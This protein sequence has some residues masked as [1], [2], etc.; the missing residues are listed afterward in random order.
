MAHDSCYALFRP[1]T[2]AN[3]IIQFHLSTN[4]VLSITEIVLK[5]IGFTTK[6][7]KQTTFSLFRE[8]ASC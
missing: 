6:I 5:E 3:K 4:I 7:L 8:Q 2:R 1:I